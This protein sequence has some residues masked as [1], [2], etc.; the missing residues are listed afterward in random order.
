MTEI[1]FVSKSKYEWI[2]ETND[3]STDLSI[4]VVLFWYGSVAH[5]ANV[6]QRNLQMI[7]DILKVQNGPRD[8][9]FLRTKASDVTS[10]GDAMQAT[11]NHMIETMLAPNADGDPRGVGLAGPQ[12]GIGLNIFVMR[13][14]HGMEH[15]T[16]EAMVVINPH[17]VIEYN[18][19]YLE[20][21]GCLS[22]PGLVGKVRR[23][24]EL[25]VIFWDAYGNR[26]GLHLK[27]FVSRVFQ[28]EYDHLLGILF[29]DRTKDL[30][31]PKKK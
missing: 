4:N 16:R 9:A 3:R 20:I 28:H 18:D 11:A 24:K 27:G 13:T 23:Y 29:T 7:L 1:N 15:D 21:E 10:F 30:Y 5:G 12:V 19:D 17:V 26:Q 14:E 6:S 25:G 22:I 8:A 31:V 2:D